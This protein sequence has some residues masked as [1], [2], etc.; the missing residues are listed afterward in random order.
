MATLPDQPI[1]G[2]V[3]PHDGHSDPVGPPF[4]KRL[5]QLVLIAALSVLGVWVVWDFLPALGWAVV[6][7][8][9]VWPLFGRLVASG[10][11]RSAGAAIFTLLLASS[12]SF[13]SPCSPSRSAARPSLSSNGSER[14]NRRASPPLPGS[15]ACP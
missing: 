2:A 3:I 1:S 15:R 14:P 8:I 13:R 12:C 4:S 7:A 5:G 11:N 9:A 10:V 6:V